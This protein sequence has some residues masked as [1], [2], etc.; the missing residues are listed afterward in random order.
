[1][2]YH[3]ITLQGK[4]LYGKTHYQQHFDNTANCASGSLRKRKIR[5]DG[6]TQRGKS[7]PFATCTKSAETFVDQQTDKDLLTTTTYLFQLQLFAICR[8]K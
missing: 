8:G 7:R 5:R 3:G 1:M 4:S 6:G 2:L